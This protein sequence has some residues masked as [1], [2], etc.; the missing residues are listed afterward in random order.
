MGT[1]GMASMRYL[2]WYDWEIHA[3]KFNNAHSSLIVF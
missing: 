2:N 3:E 1:Q